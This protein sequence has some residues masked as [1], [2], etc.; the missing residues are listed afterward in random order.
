MLKGLLQC[1]DLPNTIPEKSDHSGRYDVGIAQYAFGQQRVQLVRHHEESEFTDVLVE[2]DTYDRQ[3]A[4]QLVYHIAKIIA[5]KGNPV[6][7][8]MQ[9][10]TDWC[11]H[12]EESRIRLDNTPMH[13]PAFYENKNPLAELIAG[14]MESVFHLKRL[15]EQTGDPVAKAVAFRN[16]PL[17]MQWL[18]KLSQSM[19][20]HKYTRISSEVIMSQIRRDDQRREEERRRRE[21]EA[22]PQA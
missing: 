20:D 16:D 21:Q 3:L 14:L 13:S 1:A 17:S 6:T 5:A 19:A 10:R 4:D 2:M 9:L 7:Y 15:A 8:C 18:A 22:E 12:G 11:C